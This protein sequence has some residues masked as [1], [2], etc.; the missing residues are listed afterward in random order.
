VKVRK[1]VDTVAIQVVGGRGGNGCLSFRR[2]KYVAKGGPDGGDGGHG[3]NVILKVDPNTDSLISLFFNPLQRAQDGVHGKG[4][5]LYGRNGRDLIIPVPSG[6]E[7]RETG[8]DLLLGDL[9][10][11]G[12]ELLVA[13]GGKGGLGNPHWQTATHQ[14]PYEH[15]DGE[16]GEEVTLRLDLKLIADVGLVGFPNA[17]KS[18]LLGAISNAHPRVAP[19]AFTT[20]NPIIGTVQMEEFSPGFTVADIPGLVKDAHKGVGLGDR[21]LRHVE[22]SACLAIVIDM[23][24]T[25]GRDPIDDYQILCDEL[26][27]YRADMLDRKFL[28]VA[29]KMDLPEAKQNLTEF[30]KKTGTKPIPV[31]TVSGHGV[32]TFKKRLLRIVRRED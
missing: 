26:R 16:P 32:D 17:G 13:R 29:N 10:E 1:F 25:E 4:K 30:R 12:Q 22:R 31:S 19:Y 6:T 24:G 11:P 23:G 15:T 28:V 8:S 3:G 27:C 21:F 5:K 9:T 18:S 14:T 20:L 2:E 7:V